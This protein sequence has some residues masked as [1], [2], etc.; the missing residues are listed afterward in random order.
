MSKGKRRADPVAQP[1]SSTKRK[2][3][4]GLQSRSY[5]DPHQQTALSAWARRSSVQSEENFIFNVAECGSPNDDCFGVS[6]GPGAINVDENNIPPYCDDDS[7]IQDVID[8]DG[9]PSDIDE[10][11]DHLEPPVDTTD[12]TDAADSKRKLASMYN[13][14]VR[15][16]GNLWPEVEAFLKTEQEAIDVAAVRNKFEEFRERE[17]SFSGGSPAL[18]VKPSGDPTNAL[19]LKL[20]YPTFRTQKLEYGE[21]ADITNPSTKLL[22]QKGLLADQT[23]WFEADFRR[24]QAVKGRSKSRMQQS[25]QVLSIHTET[26]SWLERLSKKVFLIFGAENRK[27]FNARYNSHQH[28]IQLTESERVTT[29][30]IRQGGSISYII[31]YCPHPE[32]ILWNWTIW[33]GRYYD[34]CINVA[35][36]LSKV[37][38]NPSFFES[39][40]KALRVVATSAIAERDIA[41]TRKLETTNSFRCPPGALPE[42]VKI[43][44]SSND[45]SDNALEKRVRQRSKR[46]KLHCYF[47]EEVKADTTVV[48][49]RSSDA[50]KPSPECSCCYTH[51]SSYS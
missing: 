35:A 50:E 12:D 21:S 48:E 25:T 4:F 16:F 10:T 2:K 47:H 41:T 11:G 24:R 27:D 8:D 39:R 15:C 3:T 6:S 45:I 34:A 42:T 36:V 46:C 14:L 23:F 33:A 43:F 49:P 9:C 20:N 17:S 18:I 30:L 26:S 38:V 29:G 40:A 13:T 37:E 22:M 1:E 31:V 5:V 19:H 44:C 28:V 7:I 32:W 51:R